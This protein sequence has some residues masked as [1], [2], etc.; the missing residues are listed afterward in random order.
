MYPLIFWSTFVEMLATTKSISLSCAV[1]LLCLICWSSAPVFG[2]PYKVCPDDSN[3][4]QVSALISQLDSKDYQQRE[5]AG[6]ALINIGEPAV[7]PLALKSFECSP[8]ACWRIRKILEQISTRGSETVFYKTTGILQLRF[9]SNS[10]EMEQRLSVLEKKWKAQRK[11]YAISTLRKSGAV[12]NDP[13]EG[14]KLPSELLIDIE[15]VPLGGGRHI[16]IVNGQVVEQSPAPNSRT[17]VRAN[18]PTKK[19]LSSTQAKKEIERIL[20]SDLK[21]ARK[22]VIGRDSAPSRPGETDLLEAQR[23]LLARGAFVGGVPNFS[24]QGVTIELGE[25]WKGS[26]KDLDALN[27]VL[28][29]TEVKLTSQSVNEPALERIATIRSI[30]KLVFENCDL[31]SKDVKIFQGSKSI[32]EIELANLKLSNDLLASL[33]SFS[34]ANVL[35]FRECEFDPGVRFDVLKRLTRLR[36]IQF[37]GLD[38]SAGLFESFAEIKHLSY[39]NL[40]YCKFQTVSYK[41]LKKIRPNLQI[42]Y[43]AKALLGVRGPNNF[44]RVPPEADECIISEVIAGS[45]AQK[46]GMKVNDVIESINGQKVE[47]FEDLRLH[48]AQHRPGEKLDVTVNRLGKLVE[49]KIELSSFDKELR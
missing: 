32:Q 48:V 11:K 4:N 15:M 44:G 16:L 29:L 34:A 5:Q 6:E 24:G 38:I 3:L 31:T 13:L 37:E 7:G 18:R 14:Q 22:I 41:S 8:E 23:Q 49:L 9:D 40:S 43:S 17:Q 19:R 25:G 42:T 12:V 30:K 26:T 21:Q 36:G 35:T 46:G 2:T 45:G 27:E 28:N 10:A 39:I 20:G 1:Q 33:E 47:V